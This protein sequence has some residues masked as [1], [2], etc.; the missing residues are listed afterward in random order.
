MYVCM[1]G[2]PILTRNLTVATETCIPIVVAKSSFSFVEV[3]MMYKS[4][5]VETSCITIL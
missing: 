4:K 5:V 2:Y 3:F 1:M